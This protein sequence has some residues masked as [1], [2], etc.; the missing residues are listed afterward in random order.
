M[1]KTERS[2]FIANFNRYQSN[3][4]YNMT[5]IGPYKGELIQLYLSFKYQQAKEIDGKSYCRFSIELN[6]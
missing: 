4:A 1:P 3:D 6:F 2:L 5:E